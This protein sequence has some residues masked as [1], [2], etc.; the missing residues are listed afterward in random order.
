MRTD[1][2]IEATCQH[3]GITAG[4]F[5][6]GRK[7]AH[8]DARRVVACALLRCGACSSYAD[9]AVILGISRQGVHKGIKALEALAP[10]NQSLR[11]ALRIAREHCAKTLHLA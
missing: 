8:S 7:V 4:E 3:F 1:K 10:Y 5:K 6:S 2:L 11:E 9:V